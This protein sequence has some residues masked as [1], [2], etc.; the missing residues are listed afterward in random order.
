MKKEKIILFLFVIFFA[1]IA[2]DISA[3]HHR[4]GEITYEQLDDLTIRATLTTYTKTSSTA[5][6][7]DTVEINW[8]DG[9]IELVGRINGAGL[10]L[11]NDIKVSYYVAIHKYPGR[12]TYTISFSDPNRTSN[13]LNI[14]FPHS[15]DVPLYLETTFTLL[16]IQ[17][18]GKNSSVKLLQPPVDFACV[19]KVFIHNPNAYDPD[20]DS[21]SYELIAPMEEVGE[22]VPNYKYPNEVVPGPDNIINLDP[23]TGTFTWN[24]PQL[25]GEYNITFRINEFRNGVLINSMMRDMQIFVNSCDNEPPVIEVLEE[26]CIRAGET[27]NLP[28]MIDDMD[29]GQLVKF[30]ATGGIFDLLDNPATL[31]M[32]DDYLAPP[33]KAQLTWNT[34][35]NDIQEAYYQVVFRAVDNF[36]V[37]TGLADL[38]AVRIKVLGPPPVLTDVKVEA[39]KMR[40][41]WENPYP[42]EITE[43]EYFQ[44]FSVWRKES[45]PVS[46]IDSCTEGIGDPNY[47]L[48]KPITKDSDGS[49]YFYDDTDISLNNSYCYR[50]L[51]EFAKLTDVGFPYNPVSSIR[52]NEMCRSL[53]GNLPTIIKTS[54]DVT[55]MNSG[56]IDIEWIPPS[57]VFLDTLEFPGPYKYELSRSIHNDNNYTLLNTATVQH[58]SL[59]NPASF[60]FVDENINTLQNQYDYQIDFYTGGNQY[61]ETSARASSLFLNIAPG[62]NILNLSWQASVPWVNYNFYIWKYNDLLSDFELID[63]TNAMNYLD[64]DVVNGTSYCYKIQS[65]G[66][67]SDGVRLIDTIENYSQRSC[68]IPVDN[69]PPCPPVIEVESICD[70]VN[71]DVSNEELFNLIKWTDEQ[72]CE[73]EEAIAGHNIYYKE[74][75]DDEYQLIFSINEDEE[76]SFEHFPLNGIGGCYVVTALDSIGNE[77]VFSESICVDNCPI[78]ELPNTFTPNGDSHN[79]LFVPTKNY[80][81]D[82]VDFKLYNRWDILVFQTSNPN[83]N[84]DG[85]NSNGKQMSSGVYFYKCT[86]YELGLD[87]SDQKSNVIN[88]VIHLVREK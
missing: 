6:D 14:N 4:A 8:G 61:F 62:D 80:F 86:V 56:I 45:G 7:K 85:N 34:S 72:A 70:K 49:I 36:N 68:A 64:E 19:D 48:I 39:N 76:H 78:Y 60:Q 40:V 65:F 30:T 24:S 5:A 23:V 87:D 54:V 28:I 12:A 2:S 73:N 15:V 20:G 75:V 67:F 84:W 27:L 38:K 11:G 58:Q 17:F 33:Y 66:E 82:R 18:Q 26:I 29:E 59:L 21:L 37:T 10:S 57:P 3:T 71:V 9:N 46:S 13:I 32:T 16:D 25:K 51:A 1:L 47:V 83:I 88:G 63:S 41:E 22:D 43:N 50:V 42:C 44:G 74:K 81:I 52:S 55:G 77:S 35:C 31:T 69:R 53:A 79:D